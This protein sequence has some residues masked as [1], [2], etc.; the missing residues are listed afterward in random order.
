MPEVSDSWIKLNYWYLNNRRELTRWW[1]LL[2]AVLDIFLFVYVVTNIVLSFFSFSKER[3]YIATIANDRMVALTERE[4]NVPK[5]LV[6]KSVESVELASGKKLYL[7]TIKN[8][9]AYWSIR[10]VS[11]VF[12]GSS[13]S[14]SKTT[15]LLPQEERQLV[16][17]GDIGTN[18][19]L[20]VS[21]TE[22]NRSPARSLPAISVTFA[23]AKHG[24]IS[25]QTNG[26]IR[27]V[28]EV[29]TSVTNAS[30]YS[31]K[32]MKGTLVVRNGNELVNAWQFFIDN[33]KPSETRPL[34][35]QF[36][37]ALGQFTSLTFYPE[38]NTLLPDTL[39]F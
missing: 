17:T 15:F 16:F 6:V 2:F 24:L 9:N 37:E 28:S 19:S 31:I 18:P 7:A 3:A 34:T 14:D 25:A 11:Y 10:S 29:T 12:S 33:L 23:A 36:N 22:W 1:V 4:R 8:D 30:L 39:N 35:I 26:P 13:K 21:D 27:V 38:I 32:S 20:V 5:D